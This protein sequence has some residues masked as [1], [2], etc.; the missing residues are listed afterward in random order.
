MT[1]FSLQLS[2]LKTILTG[3][4][5]MAKLQNSEN[6][7]NEKKKKKRKQEKIVNFGS[8]Y[9]EIAMTDF[10]NSSSDIKAIFA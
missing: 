10:P 1:Q 8:L 3:S 2:F 9:F 6:E 4:E 5:K 7:K